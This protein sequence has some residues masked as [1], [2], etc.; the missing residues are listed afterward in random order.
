MLELGMPKVKLALAPPIFGISVNS[1]PTVG[2]GGD[3]SQNIHNGTPYFLP[4]AVLA[5]DAIVAENHG[6]LLERNNFLSLGTDL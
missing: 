3:Y 4:S 2:K 1:I 6:I 5:S